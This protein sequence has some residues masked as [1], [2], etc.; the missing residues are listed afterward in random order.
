MTR[1]A[2]STTGA[3]AALGP[4]SQ[5]IA[6]EGLLFC[7]GQI[8]LDP[9]TGELPDG[10]EAQAER[11]L[12]NLEAVLAADGLGWGDVVKTTIFLADVGDF[13]TVNAIYAAHQADPPPARSTFAVGA[14]PR[15]ALIEIEAIARRR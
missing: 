9:A 3:P 7:S 13:A 15:G 8:G 12:A 10:I 5:A 14:L 4:Y 11:V 1:Q 2:I 6:T